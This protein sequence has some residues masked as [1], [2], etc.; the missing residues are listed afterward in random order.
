[1][2]LLFWFLHTHWLQSAV[3]KHFLQLFKNIIHPKTIIPEFCNA[4]IH[5]NREKWKRQKRIKLSKLCL[6]CDSVKMFYKD[7]K[8]I[9]IIKS[10]VYTHD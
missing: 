10:L 1:M 3:N 2:I 7:Y 8:F 5:D 6:K 9:F 4:N